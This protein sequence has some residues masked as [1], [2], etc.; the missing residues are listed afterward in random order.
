MGHG[1][2]PNK[3]RGHGRLNKK[4]LVVTAIVATI[5]LVIV[6]SLLL[7]VAAFILKAVLGQ[8]DS[9]LGQSLQNAIKWLW[10]LGLDFLRSLW[11]NILSNPLRFL[12][13]GN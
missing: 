5:I 1:Y 8:A 9:G 11:Q 10:G 6:I 12:Q 3:Y 2:F 13:G 4:K 7:L